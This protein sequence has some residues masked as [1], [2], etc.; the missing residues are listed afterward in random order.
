MFCVVVDLNT[1]ILRSGL[2]SVLHLVPEIGQIVSDLIDLAALEIIDRDY[3]FY[4]GLKID[5]IAVLVKVI[6]GI[7]EVSLHILVIV[8]VHIKEVVGNVPCAVGLYAESIEIL[9]NYGSFVIHIEAEAEGVL[10][11]ILFTFPVKVASHREFVLRVV[12]KSRLGC[13]EVDLHVSAGLLTVVVGLTA[14]LS[15]FLENDLTRY[16]V[17][18][19]HLDRLRVTEKSRRN[20]IELE[21]SVL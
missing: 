5:G 11:V 4:K 17:G 21:V 1:D 10:T 15:L 9:A 13:I 20:I 2:A 19:G 14:V 3:S 7:E 6:V 8:N 18:D 12:R 16:C